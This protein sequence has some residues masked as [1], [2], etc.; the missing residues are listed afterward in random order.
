MC[1]QTPL[2]CDI[3]GT[4]PCIINIRSDDDDCVGEDD[5]D[6]D[7]DDGDNDEH[8]DGDDQET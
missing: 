4:Q 8:D 3:S 6:I 5:D 7:D 2:Q 1:G